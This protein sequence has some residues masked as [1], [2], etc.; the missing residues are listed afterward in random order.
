MKED[1]VDFSTYTANVKR[2]RPAPRKG[3]K[4]GVRDD[5]DDNDDDEDWSGGARRL[6]YSGRRGGQTRSRQR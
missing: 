6:S 1:T 3:R 5:D 4:S 2:K